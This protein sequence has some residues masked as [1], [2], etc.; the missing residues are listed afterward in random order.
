MDIIRNFEQEL[1]DAE[2]GRQERMI[3]RAVAS[4]LITQEGADT[5][6]KEIWNG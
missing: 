6:L 4:G 5:L 1:F 3:I 2:L